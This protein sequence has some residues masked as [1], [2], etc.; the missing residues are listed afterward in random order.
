M[1]IKDVLADILLKFKD[2]SI[3]AALPYVV[4]PQM[5][6]PSNKWNLLNR[7]LIFLSGTADARGFNQWQEAGRHVMSGAKAVYILAPRFR[8]V[9]DKDEDKSISILSGF[10][11]IP[12]FR[13]EDTDGE[14][15]DYQKIE[16]PPFPLMDVAEELGVSVKAIPGNFRYYGY[17]QP[18][19]KEIRLATPEE[20]VFWHELAHAAHHKIKGDMVRGQDWKQEIV[21]ELSASALAHI[22]GTK[23]N[24]GKNYAYIESYAKQAGKSPI[25][26]CLEVMSDTDK[27]LHLLLKDKLLAAA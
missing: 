20:S 22:V 8:K 11:G 12:V 3:P 25:Q 10:L 23:I 1:K 26:A 19:T 5:V 16:L 15:L 13:V 2:G 21:A 7:T 4:F 9:E 17:Y 18:D 24:L 6:C 14:P 27:V